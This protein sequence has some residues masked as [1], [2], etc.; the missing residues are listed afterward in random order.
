MNQM[1]PGLLCEEG[2]IFRW[3]YINMNLMDP[4]HVNEENPRSFK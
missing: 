2:R 3:F 1:D 4:T